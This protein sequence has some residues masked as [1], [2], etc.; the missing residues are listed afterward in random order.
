MQKV[1]AR[2][3]R[4]DIQGVLQ[5]YITLFDYLKFLSWNYVYCL[6]FMGLG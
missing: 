5:S 6:C 4:G 1:P 3:L 2:I